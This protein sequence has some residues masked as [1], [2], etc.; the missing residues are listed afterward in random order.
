VE[1]RA[2]SAYVSFG[3]KTVKGCMSCW[4]HSSSNCKTFSKMPR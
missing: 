4:S 3:G 1:N 2:R